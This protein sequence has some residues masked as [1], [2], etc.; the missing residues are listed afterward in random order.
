MNIRLRLN[1]RYQALNITIT[2]N[3]G[4]Y[5]IVGLESSARFLH[6]CLSLLLYDS[7]QNKVQIFYNIYRTYVQHEVFKIVSFGLFALLFV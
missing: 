6:S 1:E 2:S 4:R 3:V 5:N 7:Y